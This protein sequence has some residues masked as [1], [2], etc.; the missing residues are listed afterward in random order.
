M[1]HWIRSMVARAGARIEQLSIGKR[2][3]K[4]KSFLNAKD[5]AFR[6]IWACCSAALHSKSY[7]T[8]CGLSLANDITDWLLLFFFAVLKFLCHPAATTFFVFVFTTIFSSPSSSFLSIFLSD[9]TILILFHFRRSPPIAVHVT[10]S[11]AHES[12]STCIIVTGKESAAKKIPLHSF[13][14]CVGAFSTFC[15]IYFV[16]RN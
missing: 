3:K 12:Y 10:L 4:T 2:K 7:I 8:I 6:F 5:I 15:F 13:C 1:K 14:V 9:S 11:C 16:S